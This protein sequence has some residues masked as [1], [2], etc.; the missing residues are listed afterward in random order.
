MTN[1]ER[2]SLKAKDIVGCIAGSRDF[3]QLRIYPVI[4]RL[5]EAYLPIPLLLH[6]LKARSIQYQ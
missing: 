4:P 1:E 5:P 2:S 3:S 6:F